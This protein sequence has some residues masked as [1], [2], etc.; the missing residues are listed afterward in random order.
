MA[1]TTN[2]LWELLEYG[3][4]QRALMGGAIAA[5]ACA[6]VGVFILLRKEAMVGHGIAHVSFGGVAIGVYM[7][8]L[9]IYVGSEDTFPLVTAL[10]V[11]VAAMLAITTLRRRGIAESDAAIAMV[12]AMGFALGII[13]ISMADGFSV[14]LFSF[15]FG[16]VLT[17]T[18][19][20][21]ALTL[22][23]GTVIVLFV[24]V[25][26]KELLSITFDESAARLSGLPVR[27]LG[28]AFDVLVAFTIVMSIKVVGIILVS[29]LLAIPGIT[30]FQLR[31]SFR[32]TML[33]AVAFGVMAVVL[34]IFLSAIYEVATSG[35]IVVFSLALLGIA[36]LYVR[37]GEAPVNDEA[38]G[39]SQ[40][41]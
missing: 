5:I 9:G 12:T 11:S 33:A 25:F 29:A 13:I 38:A 16:N 31:L 34:G 24:L 3:F 7:V 18:W 4:F 6:I 21:L 1:T 2:G 27:G 40:E 8:S 35:L 30:A 26:Y 14:D 19:Q 15:L 41:G 20:E 39:S 36:A 10:L 32:G 22:A 37:L 17:I 23:L 28:I